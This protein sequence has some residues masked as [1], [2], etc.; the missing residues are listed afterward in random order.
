ADRIGL[1]ETGA[2]ER[3]RGE[4]RA[5]ELT[6]GTLLEQGV[7]VRGPVR[8]LRAVDDGFGEDLPHPFPE[9]VLFPKTADLEV[10]RDGRGKLDNTVVQE[11]ISSL[12]RVRHGHAIALR[13]EEVP[14][15]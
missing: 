3:Q 11:R 2:R 13:R 4:R 7:L 6:G 5:R 10:R 12:D 9:D 8:L 14:G 15:Q 1:E